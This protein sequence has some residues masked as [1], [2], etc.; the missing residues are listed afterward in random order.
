MDGITADWD[1]LRRLPLLLDEAAGQAADVTAYAVRWVARRE[2]FE[3][4]PVCLLRPLAEAMEVV[5]WA[6]EEAGRAAVGELAELRTGI[7]VAA[8]ELE[9]ADRRAADH[10]PEVG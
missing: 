4:S 6:F 10:C 5:R 1:D 7:E 3:P 2:G 9:A 8:R